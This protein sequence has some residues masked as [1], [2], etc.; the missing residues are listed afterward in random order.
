MGPLAPH[1]PFVVPCFKDGNMAKANSIFE[2][3]LQFYE[4]RF[5]EIDIGPPSFQGQPLEEGHVF[6]KEL[7]LEQIFDLLQSS[8]K[9]SH[10][11]KLVQGKT[12]Y[13]ESKAVAGK[14]PIN[15]T[16]K[17]EHH[18]TYVVDPHVKNG[19]SLTHD[20]NRFFAQEFQ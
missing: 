3:V 13:C 8:L 20:T 14:V 4:S 9:S 16:F 1:R 15:K 7:S 17:C 2:D 5:E 6:D 18:G 12:Y 19:L 11:M 10:H